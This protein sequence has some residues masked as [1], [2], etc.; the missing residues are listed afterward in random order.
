MVL[1]LVVSKHFKL[2]ALL[3]ANKQI[4]LKKVVGF[5]YLQLLSARRLLK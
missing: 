3:L 4:S 1:V 2:K 5:F